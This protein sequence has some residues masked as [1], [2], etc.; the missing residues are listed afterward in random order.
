MM[1]YSAFL[2]LFGAVVGFA[3]CETKST[4]THS[5][6]E[7]GASAPSTI[8]QDQY[9]IWSRNANMYE[10]NIRQYTEEGTIAAFERHVPRLK[11][12]G[13]DILWL[14]PIYPISSTKIEH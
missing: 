5:A 1:K 12:M 11:E 7:P 2:T 4:S 10:V 13:V 9:P 6:E 8:M 14:M 3:S